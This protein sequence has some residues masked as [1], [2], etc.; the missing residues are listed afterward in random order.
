MKLLFYEEIPDGKLSTC[1]K[2]MVHLV[3]KTSVPCTRKHINFSC[4]T[5]NILTPD[6]DNPHMNLS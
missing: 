3:A 1:L 6:T 5:H 2:K 4:S